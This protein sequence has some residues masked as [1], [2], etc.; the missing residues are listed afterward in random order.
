ML[1]I[2]HTCCLLYILK[3]GYLTEPIVHSAHPRDLTVSLS[4]HGG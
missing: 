2:F 4:Q 1:G 3:T